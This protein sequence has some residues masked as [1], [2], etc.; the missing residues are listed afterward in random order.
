[1]RC[2]RSSFVLI[3]IVLPPAAGP[4]PRRKLTPTPHLG[5]PCPRFGIAAGAFPPAAGPHPRRELTPTPHLAF[6]C[7]RFGIAAGATRPP[8][9]TRPTWL[10]SVPPSS[11][12]LPLC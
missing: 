11:S 7:P 3:F 2:R 12:P 10:R 8:R 4:H 1:M 5:F 6:P 9:P